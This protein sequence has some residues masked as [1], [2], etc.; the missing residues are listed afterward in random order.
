M[1]LLTRGLLLVLFQYQSHYAKQFFICL[2]FV[3]TNERAT[4]GNIN[5]QK[6]SANF[7]CDYKTKFFN[8]T[9]NHRGTELFMLTN[10]NNQQIFEKSPKK[11]RQLVKIPKSA[12]AGKYVTIDVGNG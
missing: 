11:Q 6:T 9:K 5:R 2:R 10:V 4:T 3:P 7:Y 12:F 8:T 1:A